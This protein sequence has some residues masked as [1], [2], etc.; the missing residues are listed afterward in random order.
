MGYNT[1]ITTIL[2][3]LAC[4]LLIFLI[5]I[6]IKILIIS[7]KVHIIL[8]DVERKLKAVNGVFETIDHVNSAVSTVS[9]AIIAKIVEVIKS[10]FGNFPNL[11]L[12]DRKENKGKLFSV[13][14]GL[15]KAN[16]TIFGGINAPYVWCAHFRCKK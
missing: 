1:V 9:D 11:I 10:F 7:D 6:A 3:V 14:E 2:L 4:V 12:I 15:L 8:L 5:L 16:Y 13:R